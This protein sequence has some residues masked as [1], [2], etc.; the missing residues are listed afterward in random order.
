MTDGTRITRI[1]RREAMLS[2]LAK[3]RHLRRRDSV[4]PEGIK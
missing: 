4:W 2:Y 3:E 1:D